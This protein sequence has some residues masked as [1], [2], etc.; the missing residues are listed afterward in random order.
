[1][2]QSKFQ[3]ATVLINSKTKKAYNWYELRYMLHQDLELKKLLINEDRDNIH[4]IICKKLWDVV[5]KEDRYTLDVILD[6]IRDS[7]HTVIVP[8]TINNDFVMRLFVLALIDLCDPYSKDRE[9]NKELVKKY[10][11]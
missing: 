6:S 4:E 11:K 10:T 1:M 3:F 7:D 8:I 2:F 5:S 9:R